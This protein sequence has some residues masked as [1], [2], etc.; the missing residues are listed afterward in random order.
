ML[1]LIYPQQWAGDLVSQSSDSTQWTYVNKAHDGIV[2][3]GEPLELECYGRF[4]MSLP[5]D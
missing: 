2:E 5:R 3:I 4:H 1:A